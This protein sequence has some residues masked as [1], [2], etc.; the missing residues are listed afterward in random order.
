MKTINIY[1]GT[2]ENAILSNLALRPFKD[3]NGL[4][5]KSVEHAY[6]TW[7]SGAFD[8]IT[9]NKDWGEGIK[10]TGLFKADKDRNRRLMYKLILKSF[11]GNEAALKALFETRGYKLTHIQEKGYWKKA[12]PEILMDIRDESPNTLKQRFLYYKLKENSLPYSWLYT[13][14]DGNAWI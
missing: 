4:E 9:Y 6:Q 14:A 7:K 12:F 3:T 5:Y 8:E 2:G 10:H 1:Y 13:A 11:D